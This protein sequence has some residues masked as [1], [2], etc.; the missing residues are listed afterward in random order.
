MCY[1]ELSACNHWTQT[2]S[3]LDYTEQSL[4][5]DTINIGF[6]HLD[7]R[8]KSFKGLMLSQVPSALLDGDN[9]D[10]SNW[11]YTAGVVTNYQNYSI[12]GCTFNDV[13]SP[14][15]KAFS[16]FLRVPN[17]ALTCKSRFHFVA[18]VFFSILM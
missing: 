17:L 12:P 4:D 1:P 7:T 18:S 16:I 10:L 3:P 9:F 14:L 15:F 2:K 13:F 5:V 6:T 8:F 11:G